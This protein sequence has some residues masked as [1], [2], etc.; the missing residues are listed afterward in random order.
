MKRKSPA[1]SGTSAS[2]PDSQPESV[3]SSFAESDVATSKG[4]QSWDRRWG[5]LVAVV[6]ILVGAWFLQQR[7]LAAHRLLPDAPDVSTLDPKMVELGK[8]SVALQAELAKNPRDSKAR[9][10]LADVY[11]KLGQPQLAHQHLEIIAKNE[12]N[13][14]EARLGLANIQLAYGH[15]NRAE[16]QFRAI[17]RQFPKKHSTGEAWGGL[18]AIFYHQGRY[19]EAEAAARQGLRYQSGAPNLVFIRSSAIVELAARHPHPRIYAEGVKLALIGLKDVLANW[20]EK[21][22]VYYKVGRAYVVLQDSTN[23]LKYLRRAKELLP[24]R[25]EVDVLLARA[26]NAKGKGAMAI[27]VTEEALK[28]HPQN[29]ELHSILGQLFYLS[30]AP[31]R[32]QRMYDA[33]KKASELNPQE[34]IYH[35]R[36]GTACMTL[37]RQKEAQ[38]AFEQALALNS[39]LAY[40]YQQLS[41]IYRR[42]GKTKLAARF[43]EAAQGMA[44]NEQQLNEIETFLQAKPNHPQ[45]LKLHRILGDRYRDLG[46]LNAARNEYFFILRKRP[47]DPAAKKGIAAMDKLEARQRQELARQ[48]ELQGAIHSSTSESIGE[49]AG[50][51][52]AR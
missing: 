44:A 16:Q 28:R 1:I 15:L 24:E 18:A 40:P 26:L 32:D 39:N 30:G 7:Y 43:A 37:D 2:L 49:L 14:I 21:G 42:Q 25:P 45:A 22:E 17:T 31:N 13:S 34:A 35:Q 36:F 47:N 38:E 3:V 52:A 4:S 8:R 6:C 23:A 41:K 33:F 46:L 48:G 10:D 20:P 27:Q 19:I 51:E 29:A 5:G 9:W 12:P 50:K 11:Q